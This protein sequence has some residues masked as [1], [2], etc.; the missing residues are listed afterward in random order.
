MPRV[1]VLMDTHY[2]IQN[3]THNC[4]NCIHSYKTWIFKNY[5]CELVLGSDLTNI[6][7]FGKCNMWEG[8]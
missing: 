6:L 3:P 4:S 5:K 1:I 2:I 7:D 8:K